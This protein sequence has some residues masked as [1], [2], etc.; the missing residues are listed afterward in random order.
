MSNV[1]PVLVDLLEKKYPAENITD[2]NIEQFLLASIA[3]EVMDVTSYGEETN[4]EEEKDQTGEVVEKYTRTEVIEGNNYPI[5]I[6][7]DFTIR[8]IVLTQSDEVDIFIKNVNGNTHK[9]P[10]LG[11]TISTDKFNADYITIEDRSGSSGDV[12]GYVGGI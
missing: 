1:N 7:P 4:V 6:N 9:I 12:L 2:E 8:E 3:S 5:E 11:N 10:L